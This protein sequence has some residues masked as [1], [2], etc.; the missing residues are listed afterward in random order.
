MT[1]YVTEKGK[2]L[3]VE[4][5]DALA[6]EVETAQYDITELKARRRGHPRSDDGYVEVG[7]VRLS[8]ELENAVKQR[9]ETEDTTT[10]EIIRQALTQFLEV[11]EPSH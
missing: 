1:N 2:V 10:G 8:A 3:S 7:P 6:V 5:I 11:A 4:D 9:A